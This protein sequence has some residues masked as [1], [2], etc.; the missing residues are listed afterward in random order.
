M[1]LIQLSN[2]F[3][4]FFQHEI[5]CFLHFQLRIIQRYDE[6]IINICVSTHKL[7]GKTRKISTLLNVIH[8]TSPRLIIFFGVKMK[9]FLLPFVNV[10]SP[11]HVNYAKNNWTPTLYY[12]Y[13]IQQKSLLSSTLKKKKISHTLQ[14]LL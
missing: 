13:R 11:R 3:S 9:N 7:Q 4:L 2:L 6:S 12:K 8:F 14:Y 10:D 1:Y 5:L